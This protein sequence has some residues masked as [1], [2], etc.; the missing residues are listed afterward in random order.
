MVPAKK[1]TSL[2]ESGS[3]DIGITKA[4]LGLLQNDVPIPGVSATGE[5]RL[6]PDFSSLKA[7]PIDGHVTMQ[8]N[9]R[10]QDGSAVPLCPRSFLEHAVKT[11]AQHGL[12]F[13]VGF[14]IEFVLLE[15]LS[16]ADP[17]SERYRPLSADG[18]A[19]S[20]ARPLTD[21]KI[22][23]LLRTIVRRL[24]DVGIDVEQLHAESANGQFELILPHQPPVQAVDTLLHTREILSALATEAGFRVTLHPKPFPHACGTAAHAHLSICSPRG[25]ER[26]VYEPFYAGVLGHLR[27]LVAFAYSS[28]ASY[29]RRADGCWAGGTWVSWGTQNREAA[30]RKIEGSHWEIKTL[31]GIA[32]PYLALG[33]VLSAGT[34]GVL[35]GEALV[36]GDCGVDPSS[37]TDGDRGAI[38]VTERLPAS[39]EEALD[40]LEADTK[41][42][43]LLGHQLVERYIA[44]KRAELGLLANLRDQDRRQWIIERY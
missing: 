5:Y 1:F 8:G 29:E 20:T 15:R 9:F 36:W 18:H 13:R 42:T 38:N 6:H 25:S 16:S 44:V 34:H 40:A 39:L 12:A 3:T 24:A 22:A 28:P 7:G 32:N 21:P 4:C 41:L 37:L 10:E 43:A 35:A 17:P 11:A 19:W 27:D 26:G 2:L 23:L 31:D 14:E 30:L 33:A